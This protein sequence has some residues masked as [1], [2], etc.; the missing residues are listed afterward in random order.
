MRKPE[1]KGLTVVGVVEVD[2]FLP[3]VVPHRIDDGAMVIRSHTY[4]EVQETRGRRQDLE[5]YNNPVH[6]C[7]SFSLSIYLSVSVSSP[8]SNVSLF[9]FLDFFIRNFKRMISYDLFSPFLP[10]PY[11]SP[12]TRCERTVEINSTQERNL[13]HETLIRVGVIEPRDRS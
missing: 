8:A 4:G 2:D 6:S 12:K 9:F 13:R 11:R 3:A 1:G 7:A 5:I 10:A